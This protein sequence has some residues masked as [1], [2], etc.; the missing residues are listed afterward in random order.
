M[1]ITCFFHLID[2]PRAS[3]LEIIVTIPI[4]GDEGT[5]RQAVNSINRDSSFRERIAENFQME[6]V[7]LKIGSVVMR[8]RS[9]TDEACC[10]LLA[11][12]GTKLTEL[13]KYFLHFSGLRENIIKVNVEYAV[14]VSGEKIGDSK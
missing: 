2:V 1:L 13:I 3:G 9:L 5:I 6:V 11:K 8:L 14:H 4:D 10:R 7:N 12:N